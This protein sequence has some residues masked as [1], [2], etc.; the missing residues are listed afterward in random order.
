VVTD[1]QGTPLAVI[2]GFKGAIS[3]TDVSAFSFR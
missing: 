1:A 2:G 3:V